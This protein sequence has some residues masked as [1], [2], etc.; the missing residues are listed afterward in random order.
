[1]RARIN[2]LETQ[3]TRNKNGSGT[4]RYTL[5]QFDAQRPS[6]QDNRQTQ[7]LPSIWC[8]LVS[9]LDEVI[10]PQDKWLMSF[11]SYRSLTIF[12]LF[13]ISFILGLTSL[14]ALSQH[15]E[16]LETFKDTSSVIR[17]FIQN[18]LPTMLVTLFMSMLPWILCVLSKQQG[19]KSY[20]DLEDC[21]LRR[22]Y[23]FA[24]FNVLI[25]F[26]LGTTF[27][28]T[29]LNVLYTPTSIIQLLAESLPQGANFFLN[30]IL[31]NSCT[32]AME[33]AQLGTQLFGRLLALIPFISPTPRIFVRKSIPW[34]FPYY[35][36]YPN[37]I[38]IFV[39]V[40]TYSI[41]QPLILLFGLMYF[42]VALV[43]FKHQ[44]AYAYI[45]RYEA[46]GLYYRRM[47]RYTTDG[48]L[49]FQLTMVGLLYLK[50]AILCATL[51]A[52]LVVF[53]A[54]V[55]LYFHRRFQSRC[56]YL[57]IDV[58]EYDEA[59]A[60]EGIEHEKGWKYLLQRLDDM[61]K[62]SWLAMWWNGARGKWEKAKERSSRKVQQLLSP[63]PDD[64]SIIDQEM[65]YPTEPPVVTFAPKV[66]GSAPPAARL[67][68]TFPVQNQQIDQYHVGRQDYF[69]TSSLYANDE[70]SQHQSYTHPIFHSKIV[71]SF[72][73]PKDPSKRLWRPI[74]CID[75][76]IDKI[77]KQYYDDILGNL[78]GGNYS[79]EEKMESQCMFTDSREDLNYSY[80]TVVVHRADTTTND[81]E[82]SPAVKRRSKISIPRG[83]TFR[84]SYCSDNITVDI[85]LQ[86]GMTQ[87][88]ELET[89]EVSSGDEE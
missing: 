40:L 89:E 52:P 10:I 29:I 3:C 74:D 30:F 7:G 32:H 63:R 37:H 86:E 71:E 27:L 54:W 35:Y 28:T 44:F 41:I 56:K 16:F 36:Y 8:R 82:K 78:E 77:V 75:I 38:L 53:T 23:H 59:K 33:L 85:E 67:S 18:V 45:R 46:N 62:L 5:D 60:M 13:P 65:P 17:S 80:D 22:Y 48:L 49:I 6:R 19:F 39:I 34:S 50:K 11:L 25:V 4:T 42:T 14:E 15:F 51:V 68:S 1:M 66:S 72:M 58:D 26:L 76:N 21:V 61:W 47:V 24:I 43:V 57:A 31:F 2:L 69:S 73:L 55:K 70:I 83:F 84:N 12:W 88:Y 20:S 87:L 81:S 9:Y 64:N 79:V